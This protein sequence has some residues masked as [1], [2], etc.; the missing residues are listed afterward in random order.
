MA[1]PKF[2]FSNP[3]KIDKY[4]PDVI[5]GLSPAGRWLRDY[6]KWAKTGPT[7]RDFK[8]KQQYETARSDWRIKLNQELVGG[9]T[10]FIDLGE[11]DVKEL[12]NKLIAKRRTEYKNF[13]SGAIAATDAQ[14][15]KVVA[16]NKVIVDQATQKAQNLQ[17]ASSVTAKG[18]MVPV[19]TERLQGPRPGQPGNQRVTVTNQITSPEE[20]AKKWEGLTT[21]QKAEFRN[22]YSEYNKGFAI[23]GLDD[24]DWVTVWMNYGLAASERAKAG[25][26][27]SDPF[28]AAG[29]SAFSKEL[30]SSGDGGGSTGP[31]AAQMASMKANA[32]QNLRA[33]YLNNGLP[34]TAKGLSNLASEIASGK[35][36]LED[37]VT[38]VRKGVLS[39]QY[40]DWADEIAAG[41][42]VRDLADS[43]I[44]KMAN[45]LEVD[46]DSIEVSDPKI[47]KALQYKTPEGKMAIQSLREF[48]IE[49]RSDPRWEETTNGRE[50]IGGMANFVLEKFGMRGN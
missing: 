5:D 32:E 34:F 26:P 47:Q 46:A 48:E 28:S 12:Q 44:A 38:K 22:A 50:V 45:M 37:T 39:K 33:F 30:K 16:E 20:W 7:R 10:G 17:A 41:Y 40:P 36:S 29:F 4:D 1:D 24:P 8:T 2:N 31:T 43:Y 19:T 9:F 21:S 25:K 23:V 27:I 15:S 18:F 3:P 49:L 35:K 42:D 13:D 6:E 11:D 14:E